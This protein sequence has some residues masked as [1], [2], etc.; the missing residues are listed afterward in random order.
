[1]MDMT[2][3]TPYMPP[4][5]QGAAF[6]PPQPQPRVPLP[7]MPPRPQQQVPLPPMPPRPQPQQ[8][9]YPQQPVQ[10]P[11]QQQA[12]QPQPAAPQ[13]RPK[14]EDVPWGQRD[15]SAQAHAALK[16]YFGYDEFRPGQFKVIN[17]IL[18]GRDVMAIM[19]TGAGKSMCYQLPATVPNTL[20]LVITPLR[21]LMRDQ[22]QH[23][24]AR[25]IPA[26]LID[27]Q[28][29][30]RG[31]N[32]IYQSAATHG[33]RMLYAAPERLQSRDFLDFA[34]KV[35]I[36]M[37]VVDE[38]HCVLQWGSD[39]RPDYR[40]IADFVRRLPHRPVIAAF[41]A[42]ATPAQ[43]DE[44]INNLGLDHP[45]RITTSFDR[46][47]IH[48]RVIKATPKERMEQIVAWAHMHAEECGIVYCPSRK[49][50]EQMAQTLKTAGVNAEYFHAKMPEDRKG[51][52]QDAFLKG[53]IRVICATTAFGM[54]VD[55]SDVRWVINDSAPASM[56]EYYQM[57]GRAGRDRDRSTAVLMWSDGDFVNLRRRLDDAGSALTDPNDQKMARQAATERLNAVS[58]YCEAKR[59]LRAEMLAYFG[60]KAP[61]RCDDCS[62]CE[63]EDNTLAVLTAAERKRITAAGKQ[64]TAKAKQ[65]TGKRPTEKRPSE[66][67]LA[68]QAEVEERRKALAARVGAVDGG[69][70]AAAER[71]I[72]SMVAD[73]RA[74]TG[75]DPAL[76]SVTYTLAGEDADFIVEAG[77]TS[78]PRFGELKGRFDKDLL[79]GIVT[80]MVDRKQLEMSKRR[81]LSLPGQG[82]A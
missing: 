57:A 7:P 27:S 12:P 65:P 53:D 76:S 48:F 49:R 6:P 29:D 5:G 47:N 1:M 34:S 58:R 71:A 10:Q 80:D 51:E 81:R 28:V 52:V 63:H 70:R 50:T 14:G 21:A 79:R 77:L 82:Q 20:T 78:H 32:A 24:E 42:T 2:G 74:S 55:K 43:R 11:V 26:A 64:K 45:Y 16:H 67:K 44:I 72:L 15:F 66:K 38:A 13:P 33:L 46:P 3:N 68:Q 35:R 9:A 75:E 62:V 17:S 31:R 19:P 73:L 22:V 60:E 37:I 40:N 25:G 18:N 36:D 54:G 23:L 8:P 30:W 61:S 59:C 41:T 56:E 4:Q 39:F 69:E